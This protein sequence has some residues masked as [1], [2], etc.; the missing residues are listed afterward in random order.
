MN[1]GSSWGGLR[2]D[3]GVE[4]AGPADEESGVRCV[5]GSEKV[6]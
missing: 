3:A 5:D 4:E 1:G 6:I 2:A